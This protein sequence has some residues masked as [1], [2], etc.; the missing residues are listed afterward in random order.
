MTG[1][2]PQRWYVDPLGIAGVGHPDRIAAGVADD[3]SP[4]AGW[5]GARRQGEGD[6]EHLLGVVD[7]DDS[8]AMEQGVIGGVITRQVS[9][10]GESSAGGGARA[11]DLGDNDRLPQ[12]LGPSS[13]PLQPSRILEAFDVQQDHT[14]IG[15]VE[16]EL[17][18]VLYL[19]IDLVAGRDDVAES[20]PPAETAVEQREAEAAALGDDCHAPLGPAHQLE[21]VDVGFG[22]R[23]AEMGEHA[24][25]LHAAA[26][27]GHDLLAHVEE[28]EAVGPDQSYAGLGNGVG[29][30]RLPFLT[31]R[32]P[33]IGEP[34]AVD[35][36]RRDSE[37]T[38]LG[39]HRGHVV[40]GD[41][42][43]GQIGHGRQLTDGPVD[44]SAVDVATGRVHEEEVAAEPVVVERPQQ[45]ATRT[46]LPRHADERDRLRREQPAEVRLRRAHPEIN[47]AA[48]IRAQRAG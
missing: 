40:G 26:P 15:I 29:E 47:A 33:I 37:P 17:D 18:E 48:E 11:T 23:P 45:P 31:G 25:K 43:K 22:S 32:A 2:V 13:Q 30:L 16:Q 1:C 21:I 24:R 38:A 36:A 41:N 39:D 44:R 12:R 35:D 14:R 5:P 19:E 34:G 6:V 3:R 27:A 20:D 4:I 8:V 9:S 10:V 42:D 28:A 46:G 7:P